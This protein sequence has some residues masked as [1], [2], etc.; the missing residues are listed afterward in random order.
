MNINRVQT[1]EVMPAV[2][3][4][5][6]RGSTRAD[7]AAGRGASPEPAASVL[8]GMSGSA[9]VA[10][11]PEA[12][13]QSL[14]THINYTKEQLDTILKEYPPFFPV[15]K[16]QRIDLIKTIRAIQDQV[17]KSSVQSDLKREISASKLSENASDSDISAALNQLFG[18]RDE[19]SKSLP[20]AVESPQPG[21]LV[22]IKV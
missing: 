9:N 19:L 8:P 20:V 22:S 6:E 2:V 4:S 17:E 1:S 7:A 12:Q 18:L 5:P 3:P 16:Y 13:A 21:T 10:Q 11:A 15:G 14:V